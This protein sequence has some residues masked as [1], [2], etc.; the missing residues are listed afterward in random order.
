MISLKKPHSFF[1]GLM[2]K[3]MSSTNTFVQMMGAEKFTV[4]ST[5]IG[6]KE[7]CQQGGRSIKYAPMLSSG[8]TVVNEKWEWKDVQNV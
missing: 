1:L 4:S 6:L 8:G 5:A 7:S 2:N 3:L